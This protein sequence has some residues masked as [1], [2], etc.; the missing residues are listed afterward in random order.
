MTPGKPD[1]HQRLFRNSLEAMLNDKH[2]LYQLA[3]TIDRQRIERELSLCYSPDM[4][5]KPLPAIFLW[6]LPAAFLYAPRELT[7]FLRNKLFKISWPLPKSALTLT[8]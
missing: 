4:G 8:H 5:Q 6:K 3:N 1:E 7:C 2:S